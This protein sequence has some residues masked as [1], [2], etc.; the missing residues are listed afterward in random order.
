MAHLA[1]LGMHPLDLFDIDID[2]QGGRLILYGA[3]GGCAKPAVA[4]SGELYIAP[5][6]PSPLVQ[7]YG[8]DLME[9]ETPEPVLT[10]VIGGHKLD[11]EMDVSGPHSRISRAA[12]DRLGL[13]V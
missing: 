7:Y 4:L 13:T 6:R 5:K 12:A 9:P 8:S 10:A 2:V 3:R 11:T 1:V